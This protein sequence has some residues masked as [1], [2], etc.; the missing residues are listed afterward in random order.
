MRSTGPE[1]FLEYRQSPRYCS[2][3]SF[4]QAS[5]N[6]TRGRVSK[7]QGTGGE[8]SWE[9]GSGWGTFICK[10]LHRYAV[11]V[12]Y[13]LLVIIISWSLFFHFQAFHL[14]DFLVI[15]LKTLKLVSHYI[16]STQKNGI[17]QS[18]HTKMSLHCCRKDRE[19]GTGDGGDIVWGANVT[20]DAD[21]ERVGRSLVEVRPTQVNQRLDRQSNITRRFR[22]N[23]TRVI[24]R[25][26]RLLAA[27]NPS[28]RATR[29]VITIMPGFRLFTIRFGLLFYSD[30]QQ[31]L[32]GGRSPCD[33][34]V[35][36]TTRQV[37]HDRTIRISHRLTRKSLHDF[38]WVIPQNPMVPT[39]FAFGEHSSFDIHLHHFPSATGKLIIYKNG[40]FK[41]SATIM[42]RFLKL[43][44]DYHIYIISLA[45]YY[46]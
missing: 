28:P 42:P 38:T 23:S 43:C 8:D 9:D 44:D 17:A 32:K 40:Q 1:H 20:A 26:I 39:I 33:Y 25:L 41:T 46:T 4:T 35:A 7:S 30:L 34:I 11:I 18:K 10:Y 5:R 19:S 16:T 3:L 14:T 6:L 45:K 29:S 37:R 15:R 31:L 2:L 12:A 13:I 24:K 27:Q 36:E 21:G 22:N